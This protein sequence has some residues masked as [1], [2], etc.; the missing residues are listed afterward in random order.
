MHAARE[1][2]QLTAE[3]IHSEMLKENASSAVLKRQTSLQL[4]L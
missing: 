3:A 1:E 2:S 4:A